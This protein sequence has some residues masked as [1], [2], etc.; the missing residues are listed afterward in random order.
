[1]IFKRISVRP[2]SNVTVTDKVKPFIDNLNEVVEVVD[3]EE[4]EHYFNVVKRKF[5]KSTFYNFDDFTITCE[6]VTEKECKEYEDKVE[7]FLKNN[8]IDW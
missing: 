3:D 5:E 6:D 7:E 2:K 4:F 8:P 1:M